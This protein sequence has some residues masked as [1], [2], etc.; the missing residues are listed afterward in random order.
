MLIGM[1]ASATTPNDTSRFATAV[2]SIPCAFSALPCSCRGGQPLPRADRFIGRRG[3]RA[4]RLILERRFDAPHIRLHRAFKMSEFA[5]YQAPIVV[6]VIFVEVRFELGIACR[7]LSA[8]GAVVIEVHAFKLASRNANVLAR[9]C[10]GS[11]RPSRTRCH[12]EC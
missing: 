7:F 5:D 10:R 2:T 1:A 3:R 12:R 11:V 9:L 4:L 6:L 8:G